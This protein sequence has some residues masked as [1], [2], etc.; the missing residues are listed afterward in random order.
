M[1]KCQDFKVRHHLSSVILP[2]HAPS[3]KPHLS[4]AIRITSSVTEVTGMVY[5]FSFQLCLELKLTISVQH[6][7]HFHF[8]LQML[9]AEYFLIIFISLHLISVVLMHAVYLDLA[10][11]YS[12]FLQKSKEVTLHVAK[13]VIM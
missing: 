11:N 3:F 9:F 2:S 1:R 13:V 6:V 12:V 5:W 10:E 4:T 7:N 8:C